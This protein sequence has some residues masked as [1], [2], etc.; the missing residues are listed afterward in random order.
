MSS[1][2]PIQ[3]ISCELSPHYNWSVKASTCDWAVEGKDGTRGL[4]KSGERRS[5]D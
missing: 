1:Q 4:G 3:V 2:S 5:R